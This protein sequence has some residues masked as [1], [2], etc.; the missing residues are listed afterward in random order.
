MKQIF[1]FSKND[2]ILELKIKANIEILNTENNAFVDFQS[3]SKSLTIEH[4]E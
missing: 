1:N 2:L 3:D 4:N